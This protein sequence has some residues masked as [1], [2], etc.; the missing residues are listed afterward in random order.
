MLFT[1]ETAP[2]VKMIEIVSESASTADDL[3][4]VIWLAAEGDHVFARS[5]QTIA[6]SETAVWEDGQCTLFRDALLNQ[7]KTCGN[8][9]DVVIQADQRHLLVNGASIPVISYCHSVQ[10][11]RAFQVFMASDLGKPFIPPSGAC[12]GPLES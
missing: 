7:L 1:I 2:L 3:S 8:E 4:D 10:T 12:E 5:G 9:T 6:E 11:P